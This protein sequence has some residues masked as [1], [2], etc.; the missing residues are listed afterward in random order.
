MSQNGS[1][2]S[3]KVGDNRENH[4]TVIMVKP[5]Q[6]FAVEQSDISQNSGEVTPVSKIS[7]PS[8]KAKVHAQEFSLNHRSFSHGTEKTPSTK[9]REKE[10]QA[11][12]NP[13]PTQE[14]IDS[15]VKLRLF[16]IKT[17]NN[18]DFLRANLPRASFSDNKHETKPDNT[19]APNNAGTEN[20]QSPAPQ[21]M[22]NKNAGDANREINQ[23]SKS[24]WCSS[25]RCC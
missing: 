17:Q 25:L 5:K 1:R 10:F 20:K 9:T 13:G 12:L 7:V 6:E 18:A 24:S 11:S 19:G 2:S 15:L 8:K 23:S 3:I 21:H 14:Q 4:G 22:E 16:A